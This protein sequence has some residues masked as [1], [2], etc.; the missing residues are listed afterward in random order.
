MT[1]ILIIVIAAVL[2]CGCLYIDQNKLQSIVEA[3]EDKWD[4]KNINDYSF[5]VRFV[6]YSEE[7][8]NYGTVY[9]LL[10]SIDNGVKTYDTT[11]L[12]AL[13][14]ERA[15][16]SVKS[17]KEYFSMI[18]EAVRTD[19]DQVEVTYDKEYGYPT[20]IKIHWDKEKKVEFVEIKIDDFSVTTT[21]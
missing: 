18:K 4:G 6:Y 10:V 14:V 11:I 1:R 19:A 17:F 7:D 3:N 13:E 8:K 16:M 12:S 9:S 5:D 2:L 21:P 15:K 20:F